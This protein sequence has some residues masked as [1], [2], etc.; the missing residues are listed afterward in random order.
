MRD[1]LV[2]LPTINEDGT[3]AEAYCHRVVRHGLLWLY[4]RTTGTEAGGEEEVVY[5]PGAAS[6]SEPPEAIRSH[7]VIALDISFYL[8][9]DARRGACRADGLL[10]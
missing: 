3:L 2:A 4:R 5:Q 7:P 9:A 1:A 10:P 6:N 8:L